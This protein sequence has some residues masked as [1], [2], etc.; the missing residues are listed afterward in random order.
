MCEN[1]E[2]LLP[3]LIN[4]VLMVAGKF[5]DGRLKDLETGCLGTQ[6]AQQ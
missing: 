3:V 5:A 1:P 6:G 4:A 2:L